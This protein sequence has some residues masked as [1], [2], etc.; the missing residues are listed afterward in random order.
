MTSGI[1]LA[2]MI[3]PIIAAI[4]RDA[5]M[6]VPESQR[7][8]AYALGATKSEAVNMSVLSYARSGII[9]AVF[10]GFARAFGETMAVV[11]LIGNEGVVSKSLLNPGYTLASLVA[12]RF[13][14]YSTPTELSALVE[15]GLLLL[16]VSF[17]A[18]FMGRL[19]IRRFIRSREAASYV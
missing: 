9:A 1:I 3:I 12:N 6:A 16:V 10:L 5:L 2:I 15:A 8:A 4:S 19:L 17:M 7:E 11:M 18:S 14:D 13:N